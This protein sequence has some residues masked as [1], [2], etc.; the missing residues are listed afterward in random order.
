MVSQLLGDF[1]SSGFL[2][3]HTVGILGW[4][5]LGCGGVLC[6]VGCPAAL[7]ASTHYIPVVLK[8]FQL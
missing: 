4:I 1:V 2:S 5:I 7:L 3:V 8:P 6:L